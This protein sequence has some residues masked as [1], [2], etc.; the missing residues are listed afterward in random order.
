MNSVAPP[1]LVL[2][3]V[4]SLTHSPP[5][6]PRQQSGDVIRGP[7]LAHKA[8]EEGIA[9]AEHLN[10]DAWSMHYNAIPGVIYT[11]PEVA[12][13][14]KT[15][16][17]LKA[18]GIKYKKG[19]FPFLANSRAKTNA[20]TDGFV[21]VLA[22][23]EDDQLYGVWIINNN[24]GELIAPAVVGLT[25]GASSEDLARTCWAHPVRCVFFF[26]IAYTLFCE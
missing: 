22:S 2:S 10:G 11:A 3:C 14:G 13:V 23:A 17:E 4:I 8:E 6:T 12:W 20:E 5:P 25:W 7:M 1:P 21:K 15:E 24:A 26:F 19:V 16:E 9:I 18:E